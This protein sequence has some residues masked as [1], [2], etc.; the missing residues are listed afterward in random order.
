MLYDQNLENSQLREHAK[1]LLEEYKKVEKRSKLHEVR[2][3]KNTVVYCKNK[4]QIEKYQ[5]KE[6][7]TIVCRTEN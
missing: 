4:D 6:K 3:N 7:E 1:E 2:L 5:R